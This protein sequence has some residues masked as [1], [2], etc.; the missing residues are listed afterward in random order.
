MPV[1]QRIDDPMEK[2]W[3]L[4]RDRTSDHDRT[5]RYSQNRRYY[6]GLQYQE[7]QAKAGLFQRIR[8]LFGYVAQIVD[9]DMDLVMGENLEPLY[10]DQEE[11]SATIQQIWADSE[12]GIHKSLLV[13]YGALTGDGYVK[14]VDNRQW[15]YNPRP[16]PKKPVLLNVLKPEIVFPR[17]NESNRE[18][19]EC[20]LI[21]YS[22]GEGNQ[23]YGELW[24]KN[25]VA[26]QVPEDWP[27][28][29]AT[30]AH[31]YGE[32]PIVHIRNLDLGEDFGFSSFHNAHECLDALNELG[33]FLL[34]TART[35]GDPV[36]VARG[37]QKGTLEKGMVTETGRAAS[38]VWYVPTPEG[39]I[40]MVEFSGNVIGGLNETLDR[41]DA[42]FMRTYPELFLQ[43]LRAGAD[44]SGYGLRLRLMPLERKINRMRSNYF[45]GLKTALG[46]AMKLLGQ[47]QADQCDFVAD[48]ILPV[49]EAEALATQRAEQQMGIK[50]RQSIAE[51][52]GIDWV[53]E[54]KRIE[55]ERVASVENTRQM[56]EAQGGPRQGFGGQDN[57]SP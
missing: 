29:S 3:E 56:M 47:E 44:L 45:A 18:E 9:T 38:T 51:E 2:F 26:V 55:E 53:E 40:E 36:Y 27:E 34:E 46:L 17:Y 21:E 50:S 33:S 1:F 13:L 52:R 25:A 32:I 20:C 15:A 19:M 35:Y 43:M 31:E 39:V 42:G 5:S 12:F 6:R 7:G 23:I 28:P 48:P 10:P 49:D 54:V 8:P 16:D 30:W 37:V 14:V 41:I 22:V 4:Y 11:A 57:A 24:T